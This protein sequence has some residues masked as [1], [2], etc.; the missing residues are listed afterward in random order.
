MTDCGGV[1]DPRVNADEGEAE[2][3]DHRTREVVP[4]DRRLH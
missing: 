3:F 4:E 1:V 2:I